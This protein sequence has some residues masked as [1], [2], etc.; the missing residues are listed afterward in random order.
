VKSDYEL[1]KSV[2]IAHLDP[3]HIKASYCCQLCK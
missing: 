1:V 3:L 2:S